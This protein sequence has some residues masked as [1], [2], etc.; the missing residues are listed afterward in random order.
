M[1]KLLARTLHKRYQHLQSENDSFPGVAAILCLE[2]PFF[3]KAILK[4]EPPKRH[5]TPL[6]AAGSCPVP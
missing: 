3:W 6:R 4:I 2:G 5:S 1:F